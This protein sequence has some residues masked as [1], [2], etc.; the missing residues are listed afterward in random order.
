MDCGYIKTSSA[1]FLLPLM[2]SVVVGLFG[3]FFFL[4]GG[5]GLFFDFVIVCVVGE[6]DGTERCMFTVHCL[7]LLQHPR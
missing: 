2:V 6:E 7:S 5:G 3:F 1:R 4:W